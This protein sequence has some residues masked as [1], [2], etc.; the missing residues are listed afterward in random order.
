MRA[1]IRLVGLALALDALSM[2]L[3]SPASADLILTVVGPTPAVIIEGDTGTVGVTATNTGPT[4]L[5]GIARRT[6]RVSDT[7][8]DD[9]ANFPNSGPLPPND[10]LVKFQPFT[11]TL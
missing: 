8:P 5:T 1:A 3:A 6:L 9:F 10:T 11:F 7:D 2:G 4:D